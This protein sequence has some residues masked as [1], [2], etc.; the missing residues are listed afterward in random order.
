MQPNNSYFREILLSN[1]F[2]DKTF[3][4]LKDDVNMDP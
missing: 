3:L 2:N 4:A 1:K